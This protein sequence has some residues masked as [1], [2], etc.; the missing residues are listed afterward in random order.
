MCGSVSVRP[1]LATALR[2]A[3]KQEEEDDK[4]SWWRANSGTE[5]TKLRSVKHFYCCKKHFYFHLVKI[6]AYRVW[7]SNSSP[8]D[9]IYFLSC[10]RQP[11]Q[12]VLVILL[13]QDS[14]LQ[15]GVHVILLLRDVKKE[16]DILGFHCVMVP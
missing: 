9:F 12:T 11:R 7:V 4:E 3:C 16:S 14:S 1:P 8:P 10:S 2:S 13:L 6:S 5:K 15:G